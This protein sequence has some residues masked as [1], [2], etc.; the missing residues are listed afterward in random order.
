VKS[1]VV[2]SC[3]ALESGKISTD[4][5]Q[6]AKMANAIKDP[7]VHIGLDAYGESKAATTHKYL[8]SPK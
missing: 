2:E 5:W 7:T 1:F 4:N 8:I 6:G 3:E